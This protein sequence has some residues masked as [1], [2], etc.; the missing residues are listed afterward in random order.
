MVDRLR[1]FFRPY[2]RRVNPLYT[3]H[4]DLALR[5]S[6]LPRPFYIRVPIRHDLDC[7]QLRVQRSVRREEI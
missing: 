4:F 5:L 6:N 2:R 7:S 3:I 1:Q